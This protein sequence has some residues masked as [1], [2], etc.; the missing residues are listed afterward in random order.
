M[1]MKKQV[2]EP[3]TGKGS[4]DIEA[5]ALDAHI[6]DLKGVRTAAIQALAALRAGMHVIF[7]GP[8]WFG[9]DPTSKKD[10]QSSR[11]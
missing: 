10:L 3:P 1:E 7:V 8:P 11:L 6:L 9:E 2:G 4:W 5:S